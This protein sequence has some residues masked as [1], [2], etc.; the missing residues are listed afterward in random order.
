MPKRRF[1]YSEMEYAIGE[2]ITGQNAERNR[3]IL[4]L[5][6]LNGYSQERIAEIHDMS[7][8]QVGRIV[9]DEGDFL[10]TKI[11]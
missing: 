2:Y 8:V 1:S 6:F 3:D 11:K 5:Y 9:R 7:T 4:K 10:M